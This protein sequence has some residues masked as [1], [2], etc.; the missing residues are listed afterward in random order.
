M[1]RRK[2]EPSERP[3]RLPVCGAALADEGEVAGAVK[4]PGLGTG[5][6]PVRSLGA[7][8]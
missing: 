4:G 3:D 6:G 2:L 5:N 7:A 1:A 8:R